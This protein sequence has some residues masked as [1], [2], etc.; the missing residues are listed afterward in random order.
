MHRWIPWTLASLGLAAAAVAAV[1]RIVNGADPSGVNHYAFATISMAATLPVL[2][3]L[4]LRRYPGHPV[5]AFLVTC[6]FVAGTV[7]LCNEWLVLGQGDLAGSAWAYWLSSWLWLVTFLLLPTVL[8]ITFP[9][10]RPP[11]PRWWPVL[12]FVVAVWAVDTAWMMTTPLEAVPG[13]WTELESP[14][15]WTH[16]SERLEDVWWWW[17]IP[18]I[19]VFV[20]A[21]MAL[22]RRLGLAT[23]IERR[24]LVPFA[25]AAVI[26]ITWL[27]ADLSFG[28]SDGD[29]QLDAA[30]T[31]LMPFGAAI[32]MLRYQ[33]LDIDRIVSR[34][35][36]Y[37][38]VT[39]GAGALYGLT[40]L[41][42]TAFYT[43]DSVWISV[44][45]VG[46]VAAAALPL[47]HW[48]NS[49]AERVL[50]G[51]R[52][53]PA[54]VIRRLGDQLE[55]LAEPNAAPGVVVDTIASSMRLPWV[56]VVLD[57]GDTTE[58]GAQRGTTASFPIQAGDHRFGTLTVA[59]R[60]DVDDLT[61]S[62]RRLL[63]DLARDLAV[64][65]NAGRLTR[66]L[67]RA[68]NELVRTREEE[69]R[70]IRNDLHDGLG[71]QL[72]GIGLQLDI[73]RSHLATDD[74][75]VLASLTRAKSAL[76]EAIIDIRR[77]VDGLRPPALDEVGLLSALHQQ[78]A[79]L[80]GDGGDHMAIELHGPE[81]LDRLPAAVEVAAFRI[82]T[83][84]VNNAVRH[85]G[86]RRCT[87]SLELGAG[88]V[89]EVRDDGCG[90]SRPPS[91]GVGLASMHQRA[92]ELGGAVAVETGSSGTIVTA[93]LP[94]ER[95]EVTV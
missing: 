94:L 47:W 49:W 80:G 69:R 38:L 22:V 1:L 14:M 74:P 92:E 76:G 95:A 30:F 17:P 67:Q 26:Q 57:D 66:E 32:G 33:L 36:T 79:V 82:V 53:D 45:A 81:H 16:S 20:L 2:G 59:A 83:E 64:M 43:I 93:T 11:T 60:S 58:R 90:M 19:A 35:L 63:T 8:V 4:I 24:Q 54:A 86:G 78:I 28:L 91:H 21:V 18:L 39:I 27:L 42:A 73:A 65:L 48:A 41:A 87:V 10:G 23:G 25:L 44:L 12:G 6:G 62:E 55:A 51:E 15:P 7:S 13:G 50:F 40:L 37:V 34:T 77:L 85:S 89:V 29:A 72:A 75:R 5:G 84:A 52:G 71:P 61:P 31:L 3:A 88:L 46:L 56:A 68:R 70:R 9:T